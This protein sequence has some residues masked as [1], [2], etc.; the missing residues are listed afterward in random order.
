MV[1]TYV[2]NENLTL[3]SSSILRCRLLLQ[4]KNK[5]TR[6]RCVSCFS[7]VEF[8]VLLLKMLFARMTG[9]AH[10]S[11][12]EFNLGQAVIFYITIAGGCRYCPSGANFC[13][14]LIGVT[15]YFGNI[16]KR[17]E[18]RRIHSSTLMCNIFKMRRIYQKLTV[19]SPKG[20]SIQ[21]TFCSQA[22]GSRP[23][24]GKKGMLSTIN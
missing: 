1:G 4:T 16:W 17:N 12:F 23:S 21:S 8:R 7:C 20:I 3:F 6:E 13:G 5:R 22:F 24:N 18:C 2:L 14:I 9:S 10:T 15:S 11:P 19:D